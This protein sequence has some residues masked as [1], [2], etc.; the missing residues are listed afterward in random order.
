MQIWLDDDEARDEDDSQ[1]FEDGEEIVEE[2]NIGIKVMNKIE[3]KEN[4]EMQVVE[5]G[6]E[7]EKI[8]EL[9]I[10]ELD[11]KCAEA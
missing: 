10:Q 3:E 1:S 11:K 8:F 5:I 4:L 2:K 9:S 6:M 7:A